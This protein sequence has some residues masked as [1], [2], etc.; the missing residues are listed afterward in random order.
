MADENSSQQGLIYK[1]RLN[2]KI[3]RFNFSDEIKR[4]RNRKTLDD[5]QNPAKKLCE[6]F[7]PER[8]VSFVIVF[9]LAI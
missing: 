1:N 5:D 4:P 7:V 9:R 6:N 2:S 8:I 3:Y